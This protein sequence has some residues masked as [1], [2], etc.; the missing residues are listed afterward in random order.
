[1]TREH[2]ALPNATALPDLA[3]PPRLVLNRQ[4][5]AAAEAAYWAGFAVPGLPEIRHW[6]YHVSQLAAPA[7]AAQGNNVARDL[8]HFAEAEP[9]RSGDG[10]LRR[11][12]P[13]PWSHTY[14]ATGRT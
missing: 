4:V 7:L 10:T 2:T 12:M 1:M 14:T 9:I 6:N 13:S 5:F 8:L 11:P 3:A